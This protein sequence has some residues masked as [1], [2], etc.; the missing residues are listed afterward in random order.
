MQNTLAAQG[1]DPNIAKPFLFSIFDQTPAQNNFIAI[2]LSR[3]DDQ[4]GSASA[5]FGINEV[6]PAYAAAVNAL[7]LP[8][9]PPT[10]FWNILMDGISV[11]NVNVP[12]PPSVNPNA[13]AGNLV[14]VID[15]G[16]A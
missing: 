9:S 16:T 11:D 3:T 5:S 6:D 15:T 10:G 7:A 1:M 2:S 13:P 14:T 12:L 4:E 8:V